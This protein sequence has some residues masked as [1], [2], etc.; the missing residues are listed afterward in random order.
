MIAYIFEY[1]LK[2]GLSNFWFLI[3]HALCFGSFSS[4]LAQ[5][6]LFV[7]ITKIIPVGLEATIYAMF[8]GARHLAQGMISPLIGAF[9]NDHFIGVNKQNMLQ[10]G[11]NYVQLS[12]IQCTLTLVSMALSLLI[13]SNIDI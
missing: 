6:P 10:P 4:A 2:F 1:N 9:I 7:T 8:I 5:M 3:I 11:S 13:P 12:Y